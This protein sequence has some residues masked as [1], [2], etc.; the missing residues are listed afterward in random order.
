MTGPFRDPKQSEKD[1]LRR[2]GGGAWEL[3]K[4]FL[5]PGAYDLEESTQDIQDFAMLL[6]ML[7]PEPDDLILDLGAGSCWCSDWL[8]RLNL[9]TVAIDISTDMLR[10][11]QQRLR[12]G[13]GAR[14]VAGDLEHLPFSS[15]VFD[16]AVCLNALHHVPRLDLAVAEIHR[17]LTDTGVVLFSEPGVGHADKPWSKCAMQDYGVLEQDVPAERLLEACLKAGFYEARLKPISYVIPE[18]DLTLAEWR[19]WQEF[20]RRKRPWR[21]L[22]KMWRNLLEALGVGKRSLML[23][24]TFAVNLIRLLKEPVEIHPIIVAYKGKDIR[25][26]IPRYRATIEVLDGPK[27]A[28]TRDAPRFTIRITNTSS[29]HWQHRATASRRHKTRVGAQ[30]LDASG[31]LLLRDWGEC[32]FD[33]DVPIGESVTITLV[34]PPIATPGTYRV[35]IDVVFEG[36]VWYETRG[37]TPALVTVNVSE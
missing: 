12:Q 26:T 4:P 2:V 34:G 35:K 33:R 16:K 24:E 23:E 8:E 15:R 19:A 25:A 20:W 29:R 11:G 3:H 21:A 10:L 14:L 1:Y 18:F 32:S 22:Q 9:S 17:V 28:T 36:V 13:A 37:S 31:Q 6:R 7:R 30:L 5:P 27:S